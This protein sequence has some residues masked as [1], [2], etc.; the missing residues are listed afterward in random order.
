LFESARYVTSVAQADQINAAALA[1]LPELAFVGRSNS[2]KSSVINVL[3]N[4]RQLAFASKT[5]GRTQLL[6]FFELSEKEDGNR[7]SR[8]YLVD[9]PGY[10][11]ARV[12][13]KT[14]ATWEALA[15]GYLQ[16]R[17]CLAGVVLVMDARR[18]LLEGD[19]ALLDWI[20][21]RPF[22]RPCR[23]HLLLNK[24]DQLGRSER[25]ATLREVEQWMAEQPLAVSAQLFSA[26]KREGVEELRA[27][28]TTI[29]KDAKF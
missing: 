20:A 8:G 17:R 13:R 22:E 23:V 16:G 7:E 29:V 26:L 25:T 2:G 14:Q 4:Q 6:N 5:P 24:A 18:P 19:L 9:L 12:D 28:L 3:A 1:M 15:G 21:Q 27:T 10:G 11:F